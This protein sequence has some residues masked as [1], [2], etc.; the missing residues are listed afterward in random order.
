MARLARTAFLATLLIVAAALAACGGDN[1]RTNRYIRELTAAQ[2]TYQTS[3]KRIEA[4]AT[5]TSTPLEDRRTLDRFAAAI[6]DTVA[7]LRRIDV[8]PEVVAEHR[9]FVGVFVT[10][11]ADIARFVA[12]IRNPTRRG[13]ERAQRRIAVANA[14]FNTRLRQAATAID[15][16]FAAS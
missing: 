15:A 2:T 11:H 16:K 9:R 14:A 5:A 7:A 8:P 10:W 1:D 12:A 13:I 4:G 3:A 6:A